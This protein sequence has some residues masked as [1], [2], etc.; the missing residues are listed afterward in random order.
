MDARFPVLA[1]P[2]VPC[3]RR[4]P[5]WK[6]NKLLTLLAVDMAE[7]GGWAVV[8][9]VMFASSWL[10]SLPSDLRR[11]PRQIF[12]GRSSSGRSLCSYLQ[13]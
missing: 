12:R 7:G 2:D 6:E 11:F 1:F 5:G 8:V 10:N 9:T 3:L 13:K 4:C